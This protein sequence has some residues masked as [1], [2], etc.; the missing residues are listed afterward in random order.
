MS[1]FVGQARGFQHRPGH[2]GQFRGVVAGHDRDRGI[3]VLEPMH[4]PTGPQSICGRVAPSSQARLQTGIA[5]VDERH[6]SPLIGRLHQRDHQIERPGFAFDEQLLALLQLQRI[7]QQVT[8]R[9]STRGSLIVLSFLARALTPAHRFPQ[10]VLDLSILGV[11]STGIHHRMHLG[12]S[13]ACRRAPM[14]ASSYRR[15]NMAWTIPVI[16]IGA[17]EMPQHVRG[18][19]SPPSD[20]VRIGLR[21]LQCPH[22]GQGPVG[23]RMLKDYPVVVDVVVR[24]GD[25]DSLGPCEPY[26][27]PAVLRDG[28]HRVSGRPGDGPSRPRLAGIRPHPGEC[29][30]AASRCRS[31][32]PTR[33]RSGHR[34]A[35]LGTDRLLMEHAAFSHKLAEGRGRG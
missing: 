34:V 3:D 16:C 10:H 8:A 29:R 33:S 19:G 7:V 13:A 24:W 2:V 9:I 30:A 32:I 23:D 28:P 20:V 11:E 25:M 26:P 21:G 22:W 15:R 4:L 17:G 35:A 18:S 1:A 5:E 12:F 27:L 14:R 31:P 6:S